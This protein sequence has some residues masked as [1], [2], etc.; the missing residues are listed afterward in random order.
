MSLRVSEIVHECQEKAHPPLSFIDHVIRGKVDGNGV[1]R[2][3]SV[4]D[5]RYEGAQSAPRYCPFCGAHL[6]PLIDPYE[7]EESPDYETRVLT[8][9]IKGAKP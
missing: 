4:F 5:A 6:G 7:F 3:P 8:R 1:V 2:W 9:G